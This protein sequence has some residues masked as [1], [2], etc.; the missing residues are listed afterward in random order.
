MPYILSQRDHDRLQEIVRWNER[1]KKNVHPVYRRRN[2][3]TGSGGHAVR[4]AYV[5]GSV[6]TN[7]VQA[8][9]LDTDTTGEAISVYCSVCGGS[10]LSAAIP[11]LAD[12]KLLPVFF[13]GEYW[14]ATTVFQA[15]EDCE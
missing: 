12:G 1:Q 8:C 4:K 15:T 11:R 3:S 13:D 7:T 6:S 14:R 5:N 9:F 10:D 2:V